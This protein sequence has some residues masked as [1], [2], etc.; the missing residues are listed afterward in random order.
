MDLSKAIADER[1][2][3]IVLEASRATGQLCLPMVS[4]LLNT[5]FVSDGAFVYLPKICGRENAAAFAFHFRRRSDS[6]SFP[7]VL[8]VAGENSTRYPD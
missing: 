4:L 2:R 1:Y 3:E 8:L 5:A 7:R 6:C